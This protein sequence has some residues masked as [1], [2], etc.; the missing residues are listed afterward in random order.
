MQD[1]KI[2][3]KVKK[4]YPNATCIKDEFGLYYIA[5]PS[6][7]TVEYSDDII[8][9]IDDLLDD[10]S[11]YHDLLEEYLL[12]H[13]KDEISAWNA[14]LISC[15]TTQNFNRTHPDRMALDHD[16]EERITRLAERSDRIQNSRTKK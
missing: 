15:R 7:F 4:F 11:S 2:I 14:A 1:I 12:P 3:N 13:T 8:D 6:K 5:I 10:T 9:D 16:D